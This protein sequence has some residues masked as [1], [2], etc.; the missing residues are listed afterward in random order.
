MRSLS[1]RVLFWVPRLLLALLWATYVILFVPLIKPNGW[2]FEW[3][4]FQVVV[5]GLLLCALALGIE[6]VTQEY[7]AGAMRRSLRRLLFW[8]PRIIV[9]LFAAMLAPL[10][11]DVFSEGYGF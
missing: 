1:P 6:A 5:A 7:Q 3:A 10:A 8:T 4:A 9:L 11:L 2:S